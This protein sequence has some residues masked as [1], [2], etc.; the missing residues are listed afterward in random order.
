MKHLPLAD[1][2]GHIRALPRHVMT[3]EGYRVHEAQD[4]AEAVKIIQETP[5]DLAILDVMMPGMNGLELCDYIR[6]HYD[7]PIMPLTA[8][9]QLSD[10]KEG[11]LRGTDEYVTKPFEPEELV[12]RVKALFRRY[13]RTSSDIIRMNR[14]VIDRKEC[15]S[16]RRAVDSFFTNEGI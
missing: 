9:D 8:R 3:K 7:I 6:Q 15:G 13:H 12:Y 11:Y 5:I 16:E 2:D 10:K 1:D 14:I 4:G